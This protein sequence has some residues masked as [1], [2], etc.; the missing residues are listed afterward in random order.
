MSFNNGDHR[1]PA[2]S[3]KRNNSNAS[4]YQG[5][6]EIGYPNNKDNGKGKKGGIVGKG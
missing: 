3:K 6:S 2:V 5:I 1:D 4:K